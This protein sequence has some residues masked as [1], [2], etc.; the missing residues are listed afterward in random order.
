MS[1]AQLYSKVAALSTLSKRK[2]VVSLSFR[3]KDLLRPIRRFKK[4]KKKNIYRQGYEVGKMTLNRFSG[5]QAGRN[6]GMRPERR[7]TIRI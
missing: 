7:T 6:L 4:K 3:L 1:E 2:D 5:C